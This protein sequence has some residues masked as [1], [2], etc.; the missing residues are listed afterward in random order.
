MYHK[1]QISLE[2]K[3]EREMEYSIVHV[4]FTQNM[5]KSEEKDSGDT[6]YYL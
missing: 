1:R 4:M 3:R 2:K 6:Y 5:N